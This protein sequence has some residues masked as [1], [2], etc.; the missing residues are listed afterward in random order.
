MRRRF[1]QGHRGRLKTNVAVRNNGYRSSSEAL[2]A[3]ILEARRRTGEIVWF[4]YEPITLRLAKKTSYTPDF[5]AIDK[6][7]AV[8]IYEVKGFMRDDAMVKLKVAADLFPWCVFVLAKAKK[9]RGK[10]YFE[11]IVIGKENGVDDINCS[12][13]AESDEAERKEKR[14]H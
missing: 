8:V 7:G 14:H 6:M 11:E 1:L 4:K 13:E 5:V 10:Q 12:V 3:A 9:S 2:F